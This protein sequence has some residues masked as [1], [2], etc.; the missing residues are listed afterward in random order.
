MKKEVKIGLIIAV[1][2]GLLFIPPMLGNKVSNKVD[3]EINYKLNPT[4]KDAAKS[5]ESKELTSIILASSTCQYCIMFQ[6]I[7][8]KLATEVDTLYYNLNELTEEEYIEYI[9]LTKSD[10]KIPAKCIDGD[11][12]ASLDSAF[13]TPLTLITKDNK[14]VDCISGYV[15]E[16][17]YRETLE[18]S[19][20]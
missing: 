10:I 15:E 7:V 13:G 16:A 3:E 9:E 18:N 2:I 17:T 5:I 12:D 8:N 4:Y 1:L 6:P 11:E 20:L 19:G 14:V